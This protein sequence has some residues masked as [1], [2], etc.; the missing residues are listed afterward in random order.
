MT[1]T[2]DSSGV[3]LT[4]SEHSLRIDFSDCEEAEDA[5]GLL[6]LWPRQ[7]APIVMP[8]RA[9]PEGEAAP[10]VTDPRKRVGLTRSKP[11]AQLASLLPGR[12]S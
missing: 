4:D 11:F 8:T 5:G 12:R 3:T 7:G 10:L 9:L 1:T 2:I 6:Y